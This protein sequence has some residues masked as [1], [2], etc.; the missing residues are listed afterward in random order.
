MDVAD[1]LVALSGLATHRFIV[2]VLLEQRRILFG[3]LFS[4]LHRGFAHARL[5]MEARAQ[6]RQ[7]IDRLGCLSPSPIRLGESLLGLAFDFVRLLLADRCRPRQL[8]DI[9]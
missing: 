5:Q 1:A 3:G 4:R 6:Q 7:P 2:T 9:A 8:T